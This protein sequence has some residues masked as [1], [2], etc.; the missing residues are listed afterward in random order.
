MPREGETASVL[1]SCLAIA[2]LGTVCGGPEQP[3]GAVGMKGSRAR[4]PE[5]GCVGLNSS[6]VTE[7]GSFVPSEL[8]FPHL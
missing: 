2:A 7:D 8:Q 3:L 5:P 4:R 6:C 1:S